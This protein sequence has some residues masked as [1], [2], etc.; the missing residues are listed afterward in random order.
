MKK[1]KVYESTCLL[2]KKQPRL[3]DDPLHMASRRS[4]GRQK[5]KRLSKT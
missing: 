1:R 5:G 3:K 2:S 4:V